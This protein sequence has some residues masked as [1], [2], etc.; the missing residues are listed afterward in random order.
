MTTVAQLIDYLKTLP[1]DAVVECKREDSDRWGNRGVELSPVVIS[2]CYV[3]DYRDPKWK[4]DKAYGRVF[5]EL[6]SEA[7]S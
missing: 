4:D 6:S 3:Y 7:W 5:V 1:Q 2:S